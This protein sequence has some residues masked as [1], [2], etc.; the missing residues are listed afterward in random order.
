MPQLKKA[1]Q[2]IGL[3]GNEISVLLALLKDSPLYAV[4]IAREAKLNRTTTYGVLKLLAGK[5]LVSIDSKKGATRY[6]SIS[7]D[8]LPGFIERQREALADTKKQVTDMIPQ[9]KLLRAKGKVLPKVQFFEG[10][11]GVMQAYEDTIENNSEKFLRDITGI[12]AVYTKMDPKFVQYYLNKRARLG[13]ECSNLVPESEWARKSKADDEKYLRTTRFLPAESNFDAE[14]SI[15]D[16]KVGIFSYAQENPMAVIIEDET[17]SHMMK[18]LF[19][20]LKQ[21]AK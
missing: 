2:A 20:C 18:K 3:S 11:E 1:L 6:Q 15:Y 21:N 17:I 16:N 13:V 10:P 7:P 19:D 8:Q 12:D 9:L 14:V 5:G 4:R